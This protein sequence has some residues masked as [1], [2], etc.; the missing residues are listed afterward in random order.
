M[1]TSELL[2]APGNE[3]QAGAWD[4]DEGEIWARYPGFFESSLRQHQAKLME[5]AALTAEARVLDIGSGTGD[6]TRDA[7]RAAARGAA[8][9]IDLSARMIECARAR[10]ARM[11]VTNVTF[12]QA[13]AQIYPFESASFD[14][15]ISRTGSMFF[16]D[17]T[18]AFAN[19]ARAIRPRGRVALVSWQGPARNEWFLSFVEA[20]T[21]GKGLVPPQPNAPG[22][23]AHADTARTQQILTDA[24]FAEIAIAPLELPMYFGATADEGYEVLSQLLVWMTSKL[25]SAERD[26]AFQR[27]HDTLAEHETPDGVTYQSAAWL[28]TA[29]RH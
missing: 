29:Q 15:A 3:Q 6:S 5:A 19:I 26:K 14:G 23:F 17:Q 7:A 28:V 27:L 10:A 21:L 1:P 13:D 22:P 25:G 20:M 2:V 24:G 11:N 18:A 8:V 9:G 12:V 16:A 4:G